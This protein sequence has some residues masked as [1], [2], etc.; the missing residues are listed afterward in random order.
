MRPHSLALV[1]SLLGAPILAQTATVRLAT[2]TDVAVVAAAGG[3]SDHEVIAA[4][5]AIP[6][7]GTV[8]LRASVDPVG[9]PYAGFITIAYPQIGGLSVAVLERGYARGTA[10]ESGGTSASLLAAGATTGPHEFLMTIAAA[11][12]TPGTL[13]IS[14]NAQAELGA[15]VSGAIDVGND[16]S[17]E[18]T[19][20]AGTRGAILPMT[21]GAQPTAV[22]IVTDGAAAGT[23][24]SA[25]WVNYFADLFV[26]FD[27]DVAT[28]C[29]FTGYGTSCGPTLAGSAQTVGTEHVVTMT[30]RNGFAGALALAFAGDQRLA[31]GFG[32][33][34]SL[35]C[36]ATIATVV[37]I[38][39]TGTAQETYRLPYT[40]IGR[41]WFQM[42]PVTL[43]G[44]NLVI[45]ASNG[46]E[47]DCR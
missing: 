42:L 41:A 7:V 27:E 39:A 25:D 44:Q 37:S 9:D 8:S 35:L 13:R 3:Q 29:T 6:G 14:W 28:T 31:L 2:H 17:F 11:P 21:V 34:C 32:G 36:N 18:W 16:G 5:T 43:Q 20:G 33:G 26:R 30:M 45:T 15:T 40:T 23:G 1:V 19:G 46:V 12:G 22:R 47:L 38:D 10:R 4:G 24:S